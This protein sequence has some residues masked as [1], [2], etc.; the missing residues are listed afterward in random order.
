MAET[1]TEPTTETAGKEDSALAKLHKQWKER[2]KGKKPEAKVIA[3]HKKALQAA[4]DKMAEGEKLVKEGQEAFDKASQEAMQE[5]GRTRV[6]MSNGV[7]LEPSCR[8]ERLY[9]KRITQDEAL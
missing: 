1:T 3:T 2:T 7:L 6:S 5:F 8:G 9:Y 4:L